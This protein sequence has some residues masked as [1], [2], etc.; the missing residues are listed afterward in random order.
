MAPIFTPDGAEVSEVILPDGAT[1]SEVVAPDGS[2]VFSAIPDSGTNQWKHS[3]GSGTT[4]S[5]S[6]GNI[7]GTING[8]TWQT[9]VGAGNAYLDY[10]GVDDFTDLG[11]ASQ[12]AFKHFT[13]QGQGTWFMW[14]NPD[15]VS[16]GQ[17]A[18]NSFALT[19]TGFG[20]R[21]DSGQL[22]VFV[23]NGSDAISRAT[24][25]S[26]S[27][28][29]WQPVA[30]T[31]DGSTTRAFVGD[32]IS[33]VASDSVGSTTTNDFGENVEFGR[34]ADD[35]TAEY[36]GGIDLSFADSVA[37]TQS[38]LQSFIDDTADLYV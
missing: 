20:V 27:T 33:Q 22:D 38:E 8:A 25:G 18:G 15:S 10:D 2:T 6:I 11:S 34:R 3:A 31:M 29:S 12:T 13:E 14:I 16:S 37:K 17:V 4:L 30:F 28:G 1:A 32:P 7:N 19:V 21:L 23:G 5:D 26:I 24:G 36:D 35:G 9:G